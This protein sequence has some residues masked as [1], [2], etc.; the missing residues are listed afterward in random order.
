LSASPGTTVPPTL[1]AQLAALGEALDPAIADPDTIVQ[2]SEASQFAYRE[3]D[4]RF[5][6]SVSEGV[7]FVLKGARRSWFSPN[8]SR[9]LEQLAIK[10]EQISTQDLSRKHPATAFRVQRALRTFACSIVRRSLGVRAAAIRDSDIL[11]DYEKVVSGDRTLIQASIRQVQ[12]L[13]NEHDKFRV[14]LNTTFGEPVPPLERQAILVTPFQKVKVLE[15]ETRARPRSAFPY[16]SIGTGKRTQAIPLTYDLFK[17]A[18][19]MRRGMLPA[20]LPRPVVALLDATR[21]RLAGQLVRNDELLEDAE[22]K[23]GTKGDLIS[24]DQ[25]GFV[26]RQEILS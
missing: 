21:A 18:A 3:L 16:L 15:Q 8:E 5:S 2:V 17:S 13:L 11:S 1:V 4:A 10:D 6:Q 14:C 12:A 22:I 19:E 26:V 24:L 20:S 25:D 23:I 7:Q 9:L